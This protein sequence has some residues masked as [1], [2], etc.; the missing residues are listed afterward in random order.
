MISKA[1]LET[2]LD[3]ITTEISG[4]YRVFKQGSSPYLSFDVSATY[5]DRTKASSDSIDLT[6]V[7]YLDWWRPMYYYNKDLRFGAGAGIGYQLIL[8]SKFLLDVAAKFA[9]LNLINQQSKKG[10]FGQ[11]L[12]EKSMAL[13]SLSLAVL[14]RIR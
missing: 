5:F 6:Q 4:E 8:S 13:M 10:S 2:S 7:D 3:F 14:Y 1:E 11:L 12:E 9:A